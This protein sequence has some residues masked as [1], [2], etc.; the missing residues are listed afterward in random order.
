MPGTHSSFQKTAVQLRLLNELSTRLQSLLESD[1]FYQEIV[2]IIQ[3]R[4]NYYSI[5]IWAAEPDSSSTLMAQAGAHGN[6]LKI[7][8]ILRAG[9]G[10][11]GHVIRSRKSYLQN[12][13]TQDPNYTSLSV[14]VQTR[15]ELCV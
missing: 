10:I 2:N 6:H 8:H 11:T 9:E 14:P 4:F 5:H 13:V 15:S 1:N 3:G 7:G 12:D